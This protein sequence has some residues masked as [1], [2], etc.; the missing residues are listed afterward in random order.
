MVLRFCYV[1]LTTLCMLVS[2]SSYAWW[3]WTPGD[4]VDDSTQN[5][6]DYGY[7]PK[8][9]INFSHEL[10]AGKREMPCQYCHSAA[11]R[12]ISAGIPSMYLC[13]GC[14]QYVRT[15]KEEIQ[16]LT[17]HYQKKDPIKW[18][19]VNDLP[20]YVRFSHQ[21]HMNAKDHN[22]NLLLGETE[23]Q[24]C[25]KCHGPVKEMGTYAQWTPLQM[26][27]CIECHNQTREPVA[28]GKPA[29]TFAAV[30]CNTCHY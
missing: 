20:D 9:P 10:H 24:V 25:M 13:M 19:K 21:A 29:K 26:G 8:Q 23:D 3:M 15:D 27:W 2:S 14:H 12:S 6:F 28:A 5:A 1:V 22:G 17:S 30:S 16:L 11:R 7:H 4:H 18:V